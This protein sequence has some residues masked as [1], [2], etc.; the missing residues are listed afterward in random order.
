MR[1]GGL[2]DKSLPNRVR[3]G[4]LATAGTGAVFTA[5]AV[6]VSGMRAAS[7]VAIGAALATGNLYLLARV[8]KR[9][10]QPGE[11][12][13][14]F[15][16]LLKMAALLFAAFLILKFGLADPLPFIAGCAALP[17][18]LVIGTLASDRL[19][20]PEDFER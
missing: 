20:P 5:I 11:S 1:N 10:A 2:V 6:F 17:V 18:G 19:L 4:I 8:V 9:R 15:F 12:G 14:G 7:S 16:V 3:Y 13:F